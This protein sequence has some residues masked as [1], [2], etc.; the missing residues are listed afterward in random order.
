MWS[1]LSLL[2]RLFLPMVA[3]IVGALL[4]AGL[5]LQIVS[6]EQYEYENAQGTRSAQLV[7]DALNAA[8]ATAGNPQQALDAFARGLG[9]SESI[10]FVRAEPK[11][12]PIAPRTANHTVPAW[13]TGLLR[14]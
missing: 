1:R 13:F 6:P 14:T 7:A 3:M 4:R 9:T 12:E 11:S 2:E 5:A 8:L 10:E